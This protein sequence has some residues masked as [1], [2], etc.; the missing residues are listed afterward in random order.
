MKDFGVV[1]EIQCTK[2]FMQKVIESSVNEK[3]N[4]EFQ[5]IERDEIE[6]KGMGKMRPYF[7]IGRQSKFL[8]D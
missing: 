7:L 6:I 3:G 5:F 2:R 8:I 4:D 1:D